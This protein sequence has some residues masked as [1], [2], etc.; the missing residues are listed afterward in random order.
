MANL[1]MMSI[2]MV[3]IRKVEGGR[4]LMIPVHFDR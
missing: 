3:K 2:L 1:M 4:L